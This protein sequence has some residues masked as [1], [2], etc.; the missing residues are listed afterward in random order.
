MRR[1]KARHLGEAH[2]HGARLDNQGRDRQTPAADTYMGSDR[3]VH[4]SMDVRFQP[5]SD[6]RLTVLDD[7]LH[8]AV[9]GSLAGI[10]PPCVLSAAQPAPV[11]VGQRPHGHSLLLYRGILVSRERDVRSH[12]YLLLDHT[13]ALLLPHLH[14]TV[15]RRHAPILLTLLFC[16][17]LRIYHGTA[18][19]ALAPEALLP[20]T[21]LRTLTP[22]GYENNTS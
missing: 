22:T 4:G 6:L 3:Y 20:P 18:A 14:H 8:P 9:R 7:S 21:R 16:R 13:R 12:R 1:D 2:A 10:L 5:F 17:V 15:A 19:D 11:P